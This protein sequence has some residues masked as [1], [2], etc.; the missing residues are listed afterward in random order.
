MA[1]REYKGSI[2]LENEKRCHSGIL[3]NEECPVCGTE[4]V[5]DGSDTYL[6]YPRVGSIESVSLFCHKC[7]EYWNM[8]IKIKSAI[9]TLESLDLDDE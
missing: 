9:L 3:F 2:N 6:S 1:N 4:C 5:W 7:D 8:R